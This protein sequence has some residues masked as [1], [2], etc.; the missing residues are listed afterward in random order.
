MLEQYFENVTSSFEMAGCPRRPGL[1]LKEWLEAA[2][3]VDVTVHRY[4]VPISVWPKDPHYVSCT[5]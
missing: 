4:H 3:F 2:G 5:V 1:H